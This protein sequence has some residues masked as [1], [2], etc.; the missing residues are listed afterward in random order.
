M[1]QVCPICKGTG[2]DPNVKHE[3]CTVC[4]GKKIISELTGLP[5]KTL[6]SKDLILLYKLMDKYEQ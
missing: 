1:W 6:E 3:Q 4:K 5:P 2:N